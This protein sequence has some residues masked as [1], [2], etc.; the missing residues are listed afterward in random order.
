M[1]A[2]RILC[3]NV[4]V[5]I[6][7]EIS[8]DMTPVVFKISLAVI[9]S[10]ILQQ[11]SHHDRAILPISQTWAKPCY[12]Y[13]LNSAWRNGRGIALWTISVRRSLQERRIDV[14]FAMVKSQ[15]LRTFMLLVTCTYLICCLRQRIYHGIADSP[16]NSFWDCTRQTF[17]IRHNKKFSTT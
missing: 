4:Y 11:F 3:L 13:L 7:N 6:Y 2:L 9:D 10:C 1:H 8:A 5:N 17:S 15:E 14:Q 16:R 12:A